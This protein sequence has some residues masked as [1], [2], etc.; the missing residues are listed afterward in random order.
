MAVRSRTPLASS[1]NFLTGQAHGAQATTLLGPGRTVCIFSNAATD[2]VVDLQGVFV[3]TGGLHF[4]PIT[5]DRKLDTR[6]TAGRHDRG[7]G[8]AG[9]A[10][11]AAT[12]GHRRR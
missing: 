5:P 10:A 1:V 6:V 12:D 4:E 8:T 2:I 7:A 9:A 11:V 3:P